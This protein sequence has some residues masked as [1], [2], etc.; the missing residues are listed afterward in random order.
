LC[1]VFELFL[2]RCMQHEPGGAGERL[3]ATF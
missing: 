3:L 2:R 1:R